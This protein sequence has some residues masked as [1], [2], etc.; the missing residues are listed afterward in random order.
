MSE[1]TR[2]GRPHQSGP[3]KPSEGGLLSSLPRSPVTRDVG[4]THTRP[5]PSLSVQWR[6]FPRFHRK[7]GKDLG[8]S[9]FWASV[10]ATAQPCGFSSASSEFRPRG[11]ELT[12]RVEGLLCFL[13]LGQLRSQGGRD[14]SRGTEATEAEQDQHPTRQLSPSL[15]RA[16]RNRL[17]VVS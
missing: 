4:H 14:S 10:P 6:R 1:L 2:A 17:V 16:S 11:R 5:A 12:L 9:D 13:Q 15:S 8:S 3:E 7:A